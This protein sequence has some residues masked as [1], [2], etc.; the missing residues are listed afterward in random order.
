M[1]KLLLFADPWTFRG[2]F[3]Y[4]TDHTRTPRVHYFRNR[5]WGKRFRIAGMRTKLDV[6]TSTFFTLGR[7]VV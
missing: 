3:E 4:G 2:V 7:P 1:K 6:D 5:I